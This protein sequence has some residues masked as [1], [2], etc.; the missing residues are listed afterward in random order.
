MVV[1]GGWGGVWGG[2]VLSRE[3]KNKHLKMSCQFALMFLLEKKFEG[4]LG[5]EGKT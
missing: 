2:Q 1:V 4:V 3:R 5:T